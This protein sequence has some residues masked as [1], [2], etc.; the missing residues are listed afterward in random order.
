M[1]DIYVS[2]SGDFKSSWEA[3]FVA[4]RSTSFF[5]WFDGS[6]SVEPDFG[7]VQLALFSQDFVRKMR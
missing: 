3:I 6:D 1:F 2:Q 7:V 4:K 5:P